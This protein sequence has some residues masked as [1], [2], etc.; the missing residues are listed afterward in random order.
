MIAGRCATPQ[1]RARWVGYTR[2]LS[3]L[4][5]LAVPVWWSLFLFVN[6]ADAAF[7]DSAPRSFLALPL[8]ISVMIARMVT[9]RANAKVFEKQWTGRDILRL[10]FWR[11]VSST[12]ALVLVAAALEDLYSGRLAGFALMF[13]AGAAALIGKIQLN[14]AE[15]LTPRPVKSGELYKRSV[16]MSKRM[17]VH[18]R[19]VCVV[20]FGRGKLTN[21]YAGG[22]QI[23]VT[24]DY[25]HWLHGAELDFVIGHE[26]SHIKHKDAVNQLMVVASMFVALGAATFFLPRM[27]LSLR[28]I[29]NFGAILIPLVALYALSRRYEYAA[30]RSA[31]EATG[32]PEAGIHSLVSLYRRCE[33]PDEQSRFIELFSTHPALWPRVAAIAR[34]GRV[35][36]EYISNIRAGFAGISAD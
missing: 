30:D 29:F 11:T 5:T 31:V 20:P 36:P 27:P 22:A 3:L 6:K 2:W 21:A 32:E 8:A 26:L 23:A 33:V 25:G 28:I 7:I 18:L 34:V 12:V 15:G 9:F 16:V 10:A 19:R 14:A 24:D 4:M 17:G 13:V 1:Q 35:S